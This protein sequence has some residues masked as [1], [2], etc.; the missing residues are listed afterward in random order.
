MKKNLHLIT[1]LLFLLFGYWQLNDPDWYLW[2]PAYAVVAILTGWHAFGKPPARL[3]LTAIAG[4]VIWGLI[5]VPDLVDWIRQGAP[6]IVEKM[7]A[8]APHIELTREFL[9]IGICLLVLGAYYL[10][11]HRRKK[12]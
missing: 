2:L 11:H 7:K 10:V 5:R 8:E 4:F 9:G 1:A 6:S 12:S 3:M